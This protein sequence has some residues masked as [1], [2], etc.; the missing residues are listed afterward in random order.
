[1]LLEHA[2]GNYRDLLEAVTRHPVMGDYLSMMANQHADPQKNRFPDENYAR[3][4]MQLFSIGLYQLNQDGTPLLNN[5]ALLPTY[6]QDDIENLARVFTGWHLADKSN[7]S[8][9][10]KQGDWFQA[11]APYADKHDSDEKSRY[12]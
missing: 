1:M 9:T 11:M 6:S 12:G 7:G 5:G 4:V 8:W 3:E 10:S 2:F